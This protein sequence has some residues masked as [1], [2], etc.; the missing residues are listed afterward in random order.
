MKL[1]AFVVLAGALGGAVGGLGRQG[2]DYFTGSTSTVPVGAGTAGAKTVDNQPKVAPAATPSDQPPAP[3]VPV[4]LPA[5][6]SANTNTPFNDTGDTYV[7]PA[8]GFR[9]RIFGRNR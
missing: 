1:I 6:P 9:R 7:D 2:Y 5:T 8:T 3:P 4:N